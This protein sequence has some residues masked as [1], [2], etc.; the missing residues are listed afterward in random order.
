MLKGY[1]YI[2]YLFCVI[3]ENI[4]AKSSGFSRGM[5]FVDCYYYVLCDVHY[6]TSMDVQ[7]CKSLVISICYAMLVLFYCV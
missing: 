5:L 6:F 4:I 1:K 7:I 2:Y 3:E